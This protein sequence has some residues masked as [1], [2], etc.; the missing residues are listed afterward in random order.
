MR[1]KRQHVDKKKLI[2]REINTQFYVD[3]NSNS[4]IN[5]TFRAMPKKYLWS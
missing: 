3:H 4:H 1:T 5:E 2:K